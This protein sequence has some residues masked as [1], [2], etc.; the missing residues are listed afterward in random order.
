MQTFPLRDCNSLLSLS[1]W[2]MQYFV[3][4]VITLTCVYGV[5]YYRKV[6][7]SVTC[8]VWV[9]IACKTN[10]GIFETHYVLTQN[11]LFTIIYLSIMLFY[12]H[13]FL[14]LSFAVWGVV[15][16]LAEAGFEFYMGTTCSI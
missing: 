10:E 3:P 2:L 11:G 5:M 14:I 4:D 8:N 16:I 6:C 15:T 9:T 7:K 13:N 1:L 12:S